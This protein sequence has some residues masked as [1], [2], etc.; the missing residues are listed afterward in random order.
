MIPLSTEL[1]LTPKRMRR[2]MVERESRT[3]GEG[4]EDERLRVP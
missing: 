3:E 1:M 4:A 2:E